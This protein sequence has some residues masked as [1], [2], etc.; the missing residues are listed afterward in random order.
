MEIVN[1]EDK[2]FMGILLAAVE[3]YPSKYCG[4][5]KPNGASPEGEVHGLL[6]GQR[7]MKNGETT[8]YNVTLAVS[9]QI[10]LE[11]SGEG[12]SVSTVHIERIREATELFPAYSLLGFFHSHPYPKGDFH[13]TGCVEPSDTD[14]ENAV[15]MATEEGDTMLD[16]IIGITRL[17]RRSSIVPDFPKPNIIHACCGN[18]KY[19]LACSVA[20]EDED[21]DS[22][23]DCYLPVDNL[24]CTTAAGMVNTDLV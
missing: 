12:V 7:I 23:D 1:I 4:G 2:A 21:G 18:Y 20:S 13:K 8:V 3:A 17:E 15:G 22:A 5:R 10:V 9:N 24:I 6:F 16:L 19:T 11:R 14:I